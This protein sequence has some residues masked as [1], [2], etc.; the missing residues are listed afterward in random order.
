MGRDLCSAG[1]SAAWSGS[2]GGVTVFGESEGVA[3]PAAEPVEAGCGLQYLSVF[4]D[5]ACAIRWALAYIGVMRRLCIK[6]AIVLDIDGT[7]LINK[8]G[9]ASTCVPAFRSLV[10]ACANNGVEVF[11]V[12]AR[13]YS[14]SNYVHSM[15][16]LA[17]CG[18]HP[19]KKLYMRPRHSEYANYKFSAREEIRNDGYT[20]LLSIGDQWADLTQDERC[21]TLSDSGLFVGSIGD[22]GGIAI[23]LPSEFA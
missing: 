9:G 18:I 21:E 6:P 13:P 16:Q 2:S 1:Y 23:K 5:V 3:L 20:I 7:I 12:T 14:G 15:R 10:Q 11:T 17:E 8:T 4:R 22:R 19:C